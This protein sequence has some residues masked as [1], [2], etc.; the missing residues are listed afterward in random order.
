[1][2]KRLVT[3]LIQHDTQQPLLQFEVIDTGIGMDDKQGVRWL[4]EE[5]AD[6]S[7]PLVIRCVSVRFA[8]I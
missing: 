1:V 7:T 3:K 2:F 6:A 5:G 4:L 8:A